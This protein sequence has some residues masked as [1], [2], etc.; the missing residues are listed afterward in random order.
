MQGRSERLVS[1]WLAG[2]FELLSFLFPSAL[3]SST[4]A[5]A[6]TATTTTTIISLLTESIFFGQQGVTRL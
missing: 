2:C 6:P 3:V 1:G 4:V 5:T